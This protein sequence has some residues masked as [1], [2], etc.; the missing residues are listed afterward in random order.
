MAKPQIDYVKC[1][2]D[3]GKLAKYMTMHLREGGGVCSEET[4]SSP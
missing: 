3:S 4:I 2:P 1:F